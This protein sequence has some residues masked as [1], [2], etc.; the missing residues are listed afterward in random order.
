ME[1]F[2][3]GNPAEYQY[4]II[5]KSL[6]GK[7]TVPLCK[8]CNEKVGKYCVDQQFYETTLSLQEILKKYGPGYT[9]DN[10][11]TDQDIQ[12]NI[13]RLQEILGSND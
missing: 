5:P 3:C 8:I 6:G 2:E 10:E 4:H 11:V 13:Q 12:E 1:C 9:F 7:K